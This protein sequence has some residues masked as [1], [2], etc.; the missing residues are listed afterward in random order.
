MTEA[1]RI[2]YC[3]HC[4]NTGPHQLVHTQS[5]LERLWSVSDAK[6]HVDEEAVSFVAVCQTCSQVLVYGGL[7][8][9]LEEGFQGADLLWPEFGLDSS[10]PERIRHIYDEPNRAYRAERVCSADSSRS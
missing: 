5:Y 10:V 3:P 4:G 6:N 7:K 8:A 1:V 2:S 9:V